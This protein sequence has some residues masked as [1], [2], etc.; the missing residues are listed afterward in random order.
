VKKTKTAQFLLLFVAIVWGS[1]FIAASIALEDNIPPFTMMAIRF[2]VASIILFVFFGKRIIHHQSIAKY[3][4][5]VGL[6]LF[7]AF[8]LQ[9]F[10]LSYTTA[11]KNAFLTSMNV[12]FVPILSSIFYR[13]KPSYIVIIASLVSF[14][15]VGLLTL[16]QDYSLN[17]GDLLSL[18]CG[19]LFAGHIFTVGHYTKG[20]TF[21]VIT[22]VFF[23]F[24]TAAALSIIMMLI[25][26][27]ITTIEFNSKGFLA[28]LYL[29][30]FST[31][32]AFFIQNYAQK[33]VDASKTSIILANEAVFATIFALIILKEN[34][35]LKM[36]IG[37]I[38]V[39]S[40][41]ILSDIKLKNR[42]IDDSVNPFN[43]HS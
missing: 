10:G 37:S 25:R 12:I 36:V 34:L 38:L 33:Y 1:G 8:A 22:F 17:I 11:A 31:L 21:D 23:Q 18:L 41:I 24:L 16:N 28:A 7:I 15:G 42:V 26:D 39:F 40:A 6:I 9:T 5:I 4:I 2:S 3:G 35:D 19:I 29:G 30:L 13:K 43:H 14:V 32:L 20:K 27:D